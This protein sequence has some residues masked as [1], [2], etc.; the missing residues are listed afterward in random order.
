MPV[1]VSFQKQ[2]RPNHCD[3]VENAKRQ[4]RKSHLEVGYRPVLAVF[5]AASVQLRSSKLVAFHDAFLG[6]AKGVRGSQSP[7]RSAHV[8]AFSS[9]R[10]FSTPGIFPISISFGSSDLVQCNA[11]FRLAVFGLFLHSHT[12]SQDP[13]PMI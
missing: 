1:A 13:P 5:H 6:Q 10:I 2:P 9:A 7:L 4:Q 12:P 8:G 11:Y 3:K